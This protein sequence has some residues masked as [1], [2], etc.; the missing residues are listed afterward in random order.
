MLDVSLSECASETLLF[1]MRK[2][3]VNKLYSF[4]DIRLFYVIDISFLSTQCNIV[5]V[6]SWKTLDFDMYVHT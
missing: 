6:E 1:V 4:I 3:I 2:C 5:L